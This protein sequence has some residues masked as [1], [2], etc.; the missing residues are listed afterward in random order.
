MYTNHFYRRMGE[1]VYKNEKGLTNKEYKKQNVHAKRIVK[2]A[3]KHKVAEYTDTYGTKYIYSF[4]NDICYKYIF[5]KNKIITVYE[6]DFE[7]E[8]EK[9]PLK[10]NE[11]VFK[12]Y[13]R[14]I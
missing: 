12:K 13:S 10:I 9:Y 3:V 1:R 14:G 11:Y 6:T 7:K 2:Q 8:R 4:Y 5:N